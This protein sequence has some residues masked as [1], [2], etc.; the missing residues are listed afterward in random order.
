MVLCPYVCVVVVVVVQDP[1]NHHPPPSVGCPGLALSRDGMGC[2]AFT[3]SQNFLQDCRVISP[4]TH[5]REKRR[6]KKY[7]KLLEHF[8]ICW[9]WISLHGWKTFFGPI[10]T[11]RGTRRAM[12]RKQMGPVDVN[13]SVHT[14]GKQYQRKNVPICSCIASRVL[15]GLGL[16][17]HPLREPQQKRKCAESLVPFCFEFLISRGKRW[18]LSV[19]SAN[20]LQDQRC[21]KQI[22]AMPFRGSSPLQFRLEEN[23]WKFFTFWWLFHFANCWVKGFIPWCTRTQNKPQTDGEI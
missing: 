10:H 11:G 8:H 9:V 14:A 1:H 15:C 23:I 18:V 3:L 21:I 16:C 12:R 6:K 5:L 2:S 22:T 20:S 7:W 19:H 4:S 13:G 17:V